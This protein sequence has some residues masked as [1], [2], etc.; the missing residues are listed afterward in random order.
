MI[1]A[2]CGFLCGRFLC[3]RWTEFVLSRKCL[4]DVEASARTSAA[5]VS[6]SVDSELIQKKFRPLLEEFQLKLCFVERL[7]CESLLIRYRLYIH[8]RFRATNLPSWTRSN[9]NNGRVEWLRCPSF[10]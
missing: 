5:I 9:S 1:I 4:L 6:G 3:G 8:L 7:F 10:G 2:S